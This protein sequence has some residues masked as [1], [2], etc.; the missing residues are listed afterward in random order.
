MSDTAILDPYKVLGIT[1]D[2]TIAEIKSAHRKLALKCHPD[3]IKDEEQ[4]KEAVPEFQK[5]QSAYELL[6][7]TQKR[8]EYDYK[9][10]LKK[11]SAFHGKDAGSS[12]HHRPST[13]TKSYEYRDGAVYEERVPKSSRFF[14][15]DV[16]FSEEPRPASRKYDGYERK[17]NTEE[18]EKKKSRHVDPP[19]SSRSSKERVREARESVK[20]GR[21]DRAK[22][23][24]KE[25]RKDRERSEKYPKPFVV[26]EPED[27]YDLD[28][29]NQYYTPQTPQP[30][31]QYYTPQTPQPENQYYTPK[32]PQ[33]EYED[34]RTRRTSNS[35]ESNPKQT[36]DEEYSDEWSSSKLDDAKKYIQRSKSGG[37]SSY[38][39]SPSAYYS[40]HVE[41][42][43]RRSSGRTRTRD[44]VRPSSSGKDRRGSAD[45]Q[46]S[47][48]KSHFIPRPPTLQTATSAPSGLRFPISISTRPSSKP[49]APRRS[50][51]MPFPTLFR[52]SE[53]L[54]TRSSKMREPQD[55]GYSSPGTPEMHSGSS[56]PLP[57]R[58]TVVDESEEYVSH[59]AVR[60]E[61]NPGLYRRNK[62]VSPTRHPYSS[63]PIP[64]P[65]RSRTYNYPID[66]VFMPPS[67]DPSMPMPSLHT[68]PP[69]PVGLNRDGLF[70]EV[71]PGNYNRPKIIIPDSDIQYSR[72]ISADD[73]SYSYSPRMGPADPNV[74]RETYPRPYGSRKE[75]VAC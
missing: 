16:P 35:S 69:T 59:R 1:K 4:R 24:D 54:P 14:D 23:R 64:Q 68:T 41:T 36:R 6:S 19:V 66:P 55:S 46:D 8:A 42:P 26:S 11:R 28:P 61:P 7:D 2:A 45:V 75:P 37:Y 22:Y 50:E 48:L 57:G 73:I 70:G 21:S 27:E 40:P 52:R 30:E 62:S 43:P 38:D 39:T 72:K 33:P 20:S 13:F 32:T 18:K 53:T 5:V 58:Y 3:K 29:G 31:N 47:P 71:L 17:Q 56:P 49:H 51:T 63:M 60:I 12:S 34:V 65:S 74:Y 67:H 25:R 9:V 10:E 15:D 44:S